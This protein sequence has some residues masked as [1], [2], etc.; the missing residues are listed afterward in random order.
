MFTTGFS[1]ADTIAGWEMTGQSSYGTQNLTAT[2]KASNVTVSGL[3]RASG[4]TTTGT[5]AGGAWGGNGWQ[6]SADVAG[7]VTANKFI[8]F[9]V[10]PASGYQVSLTT[11][12][13]N[14]RRSGT[15]PSS[16][17]V[18]AVIGTN[19][20]DLGTVAFSS[21]SNSGAV[22]TDLALGA[23]T[24]VQNVSSAIEFRIIPLSATASAGTFYFYG[25]LTGQDLVLDGTVST[26]AGDTTA[27][28]VTTLLPASAASDV[29]LS[30]NLVATF[31]ENV[32]AGTGNIV[33]K[34]S[35]DN[36]TV[37]TIPASDAQV[38]IASNVVTINPTANLAAG[39]SYYVQVDS[40]AFK[41]GSNNFF[42]GISTT[43]T[44]SFTTVAPDTTAPTLVSSVPADN[45]TDLKP[46]KTITLQFSEEIAA[47]TGDLV[48][49]NSVGDAV[50]ETITMG[51]PSVV[52]SG[53]TAT[54]T[55]SQLLPY[56]ASCYLTIANT[57]IKDISNNAFAGIADATTLNFSIRSAPAVQISQYYEGT[58]SN[59]F[60]ELRNNSNVD[61][62][63][64][65]YN[66]TLWSNASAQ[67]WRNEAATPTATL[68]LTG[69]TIPANSYWLFRNTSAAL[70]SYTAG[71]GTAN[72]TV[73]N[74]NGNDS[75]VLYQGA[76]NTV[77]NIVD[78]VS[79][80]EAGSEGV[81]KSF[82]RLNTNLGYDVSASLPI[83]SFS[84]VWAEKTLADVASAADSDAWYLKSYVAPVAP[85]IDLFAPGYG[86]TS[87][88]TRNVTLNYSLTTT[89]GIPLEYMVSETAD[90][91]GATWQTLTSNLYYTLSAGA[92]TKTV[93]FKLRNGSLESAAKSASIDL[94]DY[95]YTPSVL[96]TQYYEPDV[97]GTNSKYI[98]LTNVSNSPV[99]MTSWTLVRWTNQDSQNWR[100]TGTLVQSPNAQ[101]DL[102]SLGTLQPGQTV[103]IANSQA[104]ALTPAAALTSSDLS[105]NGNDSVALYNSSAIA[106][107][108]L[109]DVI[110]L[111]EL[112]NEGADKSFTRI[113]TAQG[114]GLDA[115][116]PVTAFT[117]VWEAITLTD[118]STATA[119]QNA[120]L[121]YFSL[122]TGS[123]YQ[124]WATTN[125]G[126]QSASGDYDG[127]G[128]LNGV[129]Y[130]MGETG[131]TQTV[132]P[133]IVNGTI[134]WPHDE[135]ANATYEVQTS[136]TL[137]AEGE[138]G[139]WVT[140][141][142]GVS[143]QNGAVT[144][145]LPSGEAKIF[146]RLKVTTP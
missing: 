110:S 75:V 63:L 5:P 28:T 134:T 117:A 36:S 90:F 1:L 38:S 109:Q 138:V 48:L 98:E 136:T 47:G 132:L 23:I 74:F 72:N 27:P 37:A 45:A 93:Y 123:T 59:K 114:F 97:A 15:G 145:T 49:K 107:W 16:A 62:D 12:K 111:T 119:T 78:A 128:V 6:L 58:S 84:S 7:A 52:I 66:L 34:K 137:A 32:V 146:V 8:S 54:I 115:V 10:T 100:Y 139:G 57:A 96:I 130:F 106:P 80:T 101:I 124:S 79:F 113:S 129:E 14:Y 85:E 125:A 30:S 70:P 26:V 81:D 61:V 41:D 39:T 83:T 20:Y 103:V 24:N 73:I 69:I 40:T 135:M 122:D 121:G 105:F 89:S 50:I 140:A 131:S 120:F 71:K 9:T 102:T 127:D 76:T 112:G 4:V 91:T 3:T 53:S 87:T 60:I 35:S 143:A 108:A 86:L 68:A 133:G 99:D 77:A 55:L 64:T 94:V 142:T 44:W 126:G 144:Y 19:S 88:A 116:Q 13:I 82:Y 92:G 11:L 21:T 51:S 33:I 65:G 18:R 43:N 25:S 46:T 29:A 17:A 104:A 42:A 141:T 67:N 31:S 118:V 22:A 95:S 56:G 2:T